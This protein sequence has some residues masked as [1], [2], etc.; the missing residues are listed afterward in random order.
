MIN[1]SQHRFKCV[2][3]TPKGVLYSA[4]NA[5]SLGN[6]YVHDLQEA[7]DW[8]YSQ[9][10]VLKTGIGVMGLSKGAE[11]ACLMANLNPKV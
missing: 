4:L 7:A 8:L 6:T 11:L 5:N 9:P 3:V 10:Q 1:L 2:Q